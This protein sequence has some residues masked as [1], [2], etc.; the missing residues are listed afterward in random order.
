MDTIDFKFIGWCNETDK[1][2]KKHDKMWTAFAVGESYYAGWG[3]RN[4]AVSFKKYGV[5]WRASDEL[6]TMIRKKKR[7]Y[8][9]VGEATLNLMFPNFYEEV[10][11]RMFYC[12]LSDKIK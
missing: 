11:K 12:L 10:N 7:T 8:N 4:K 6:S 2:G 9:T 1:D 5:G 3:A